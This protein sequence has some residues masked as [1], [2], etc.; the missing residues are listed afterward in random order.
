MPLLH[1][2]QWQSY[3]WFPHCPLAG[4]VAHSHLVFS[5][6]RSICSCIQ[7]GAAGAFHWA[8]QRLA[9]VLEKKENDGSL[10][11]S[12]TPMVKIFKN[13]PQFCTS[14]YKAASPTKGPNLGTPH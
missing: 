3:S 4:S 7:F 13:L 10:K 5:T 8:P 12:W 9:K 1:A 11:Q 2:E 6:L 14:T